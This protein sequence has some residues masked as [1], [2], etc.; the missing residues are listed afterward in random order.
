MAYACIDIGSNTTR[1][2]VAEVEDGHLRE[3]MTQRVYSR[4]G[5]TLVKKGRLTAKK[6]SETAGVVATQSRHAR[7]SGARQ[8]AVVATAAIREAPNCGELVA[9]VESEADVAVRVLSGEEEARLSF[10]GATKTLGVPVEGV[11]GVVDV[12]GGSTEIAIGTVASGA[13]W[14]ES[15][16]V[17]SGFL[18]ESYVRSDPPAASE[19]H[20]L[21]QHVAGVFEELEP[22]A[23][24][25]GVAV[26]G[27]ATSL[28]RITGAEL[29]HEALERSIRILCTT[30]SRDVAQR[31]ELDPERVR[32]LPAGMLIFESISDCLGLPL[33]IGKGGLREGV[34]IEM[35]TAA[36]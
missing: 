23:L 2:L 18:T 25:R 1:L 34:I 26:G 11:V 3:L 33:T 32:L 19:L 28:R 9:E 29:E 31:F 15:F 12:G 36:G 24:E 10:I 7:E 22:P 21:R 17:G 30:E 14:V 8:I 6:I 20:A 16:R 13:S 5:K 4:L 35:V 27:T